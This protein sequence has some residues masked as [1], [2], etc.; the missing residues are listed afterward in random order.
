M[1]SERAHD[2]SGSN[3]RQHNDEMCANPPRTSSVLVAY[4]VRNL[5]CQCLDNMYCNADP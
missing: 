4:V 3:G 1:T 2:S 5:G